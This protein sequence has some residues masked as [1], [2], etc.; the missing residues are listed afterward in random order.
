MS[1][2][3]ITSRKKYQYI[4]HAVILVL[5]VWYFYQSLHPEFPPVLETKKVGEYEIT[6]MPY[7]ENAP[8]HHDGLFV[9]DFLLMFKTGDVATVRQAYLNIGA[10]PMSLTSLEQEE[11]GILHG[12]RHGQHVHALA[13]AS[14]SQ[15]DKIWLTLQRWDGQIHTMSWDVPTNLLSKS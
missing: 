11:L 13:K 5:P 14:L 1:R 7:D 6:P 10:E 3:K 15:D 2:R 4:I 9:K 8:Y 12:T